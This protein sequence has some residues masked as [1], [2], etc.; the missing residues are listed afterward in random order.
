MSKIT[1]QIEKIKLQ[2]AELELENQKKIA[3]RLAVEEKERKEAKA[4]AD[5]ELKKAQEEEK[6][7]AQ[8]I[9]NAP[10]KCYVRTF[11]F[12]DGKK[13]EYHT[14]CDGEDY[15]QGPNDAMGKLTGK[16]AREVNKKEKILETKDTVHYI[17]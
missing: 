9:A 10:K 16:W 5:A 12:S 2:A 14:I 4:K 8:R 3:E 15:S 1:D 17:K 11:Y 6:L 13:K 7:E